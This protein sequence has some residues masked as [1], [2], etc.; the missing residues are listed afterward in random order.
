MCLE[1]MKFREDTKG[2]TFIPMRALMSIVIA[3]VIGALAY[4]GFQ[5][6]EKIRAEKEMERICNEL[7]ASLS[8]MVASG[9]A[10]DIHNPAD[11]EGDSRTIDFSLPTK[12]VYLGFGVDP[13]PDNDGE[14][15]SKMLADG[16]CIVYKIDGLSKKIFWLDN[17]KFR[18]GI[19]NEKGIWVIDDQQGMVILREGKIKL[20]FELVKDFS[21]KYVLIK[22]AY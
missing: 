7:I 13:D 12:L 17:I 1:K 4:A 15:E 2:S 5:Q 14:M 16:A 8:T 20:T 9:N 21:G 22:P 19:K 3:G 11:G 10:R 18:K 6:M